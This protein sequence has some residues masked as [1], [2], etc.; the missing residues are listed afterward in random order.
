MGSSCTFH[1]CWAEQ[2]FKKLASIWSFVQ[3][4]LQQALSRIIL[5]N[6]NFVFCQLQKF[7]IR[8]SYYNMDS[9]FLPMPPLFFHALHCGP[10]PSDRNWWLLLIMFASGNKTSWFKSWDC[11]SWRWIFWQPCT[12]PNIFHFAERLNFK[13]TKMYLF[14]MLWGKVLVHYHD[15]ESLGFTESFLGFRVRNGGHWC[16]G[17]TLSG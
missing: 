2:K 9:C 8:A 14:S 15:I 10:D 6:I 7:Q 1:D 12:L 17:C 5:Q 11:N 4:L 16:L 3:Q 13:S